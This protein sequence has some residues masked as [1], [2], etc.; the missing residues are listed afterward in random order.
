MKS[1]GTRIGMFEIVET[2]GRG[3]LVLCGGEAPSWGHASDNGRDLVGDL[4]HVPS[5]IMHGIPREG[6]AIPR[7]QV[8]VSDLVEPGL[9]GRGEDNRIEM[10][11]L[12]LRLPF[13]N[14][15]DLLVDDVVRR[16]RMSRDEQYEDVAR[17]Q[18]SLDLRIPVRP[19]EHMAVVP[20]SENP[21]LPRRSEVSLH[22]R[23]P[24][25][26]ALGRLLGFVL[27]A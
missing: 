6:L 13:T 3:G 19:A 17:A 22:I 8:L 9:R 26:L 23:Q 7:A 18:V 20:V 25:H 16:H 11:R 5:T 15:R 1:G 27:M 10:N 24:L 21:V 4:R 12:A 2:L 14:N